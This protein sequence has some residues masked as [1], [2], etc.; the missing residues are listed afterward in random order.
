MGIRY[1]RHA[2]SIEKNNKM[3]ITIGYGKVCF[4]EQLRTMRLSM[5]NM[6]TLWRHAYGIFYFD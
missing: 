5:G 6:R 3:Y 1:E 4:S 2:R